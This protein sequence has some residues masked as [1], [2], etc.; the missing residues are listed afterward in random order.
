MPDNEPAGPA[1]QLPHRFLFNVNFVFIAS[2]TSNTVGFF[3]VILLARA[4]GP[5]GRGVAALY[6]AAVNL[7]FAFLNLGIASAA[8][9]FVTRAELRGREAA[10]AG[11][12]ISLAAAGVTGLGVLITALFFAGRFQEYHLPYWLAIVAVPAIIQLR[13][14][15]A[16]LRAEGRF[17]AMNG[18]DLGLPLSMLICLGSV[19]LI[20]DL[21]VASAI[22][23]WSL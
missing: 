13:M 16:L 5:D 14:T 22:W 4:L 10:E 8:F 11:L 12:T 21:T 23:A 2:L 19:E 1:Q 7:G 17:G 18:V 9:Y 6:Q 20:T 3:A 15:I